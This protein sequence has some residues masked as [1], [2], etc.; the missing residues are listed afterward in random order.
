M[1]H[2]ERLNI[3]ADQQHGFRKGRSCEA[4]LSVLVDDLQKILDRRS[5]A[6]LVIMDLSKAF[7]TVPHQCLLAKLHHNG[8]RNNILS[9]IDSFLTQRHQRV[10]VDGESS[11]QSP[12]ASGV[13][14]GTVLGPLLF[15]V[16]IT[17]LPTNLS[18]NMRLFADDCILYREVNSKQD[19][20]SL[21]KDINSLKDWESSWQMG[22]NTAKCFVMRITHNL[23]QYTM[24]DH[25]FQ[26]VKSHP[27]LGVELSS[28]MSWNKHINQISTKANRTLGLLR[29]NLSCCD[30]STKSTA[31]PG[32]NTWVT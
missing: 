20:E 7:D 16:Y 27:Y 13:S 2:F 22:F 1:K 29:R 12:V 19:T 26:E 14:Q 21:Q 8:I 6:D 32:I 30:R 31:Y 9:W 5:Q 10:V 11:H 3:L 17:D 18:N 23:N 28:D 15:L 24:G 25:I 4:Q